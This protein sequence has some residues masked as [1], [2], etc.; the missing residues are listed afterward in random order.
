[1]EEI[2]LGMTTRE[3]LHQRVDELPEDQTELA[4]ACLQDLHGA[5]DEDGC[6]RGIFALRGEIGFCQSRRAALALADSGMRGEGIALN[7]KT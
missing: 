1:M 3:A 5:A 7:S 6:C 2:G 4:H